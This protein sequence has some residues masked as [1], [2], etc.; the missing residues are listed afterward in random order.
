RLRHYW[1]RLKGAQR[2]DLL[3]ARLLGRWL[4]DRLYMQ[5]GHALYFRR[6]PDFESP[7]LLS[8]HI[9]AY[10][11]RCRDPLLKVAADKARTREYVA[12]VAGTQYLVPLYGVWERAEDVPLATLPR[13]CVLKPTAASGLVH[14]LRAPLTPSPSPGG[15]GEEV[16]IA[17]PDGA[18]LAVSEADL[19][20]LRLTLHKWL[21]RDYSRDH[22]EWSYAGVRQRILA[23][24]ML[25]DA[26]GSVPR[27]CKAWV[28]GGKVRM[29]SVDRRRFTPQHTRN[30]YGPDWQLMHGRLLPPRN[31][32][33]DPRPPQLA[34]IIA[35]AEAIAAPFE[36]L[37]VDFL[38]HGD[39]FYV[40]ELTNSPGAGYE[41]FEPQ[42]ISLHLGSFWRP[43]APREREE[44]ARA[45]AGRE[46]IY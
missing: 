34:E 25:L 23:E 46:E 13:P 20:Q 10:T 43:R 21:R 44:R 3:A 11:L 22:R 14:F 33:P 6:W 35:V 5:L 26:D 1:S 30:L 29:L 18:A 12:A 7:R 32:A 27:D 8:E 4:P 31:H 36:F 42:S 40:N 9:M 19:E 17:A 16:G 2:P 39:A 24:Q 45:S 38:L 15:R 41:K 37:R 28:I